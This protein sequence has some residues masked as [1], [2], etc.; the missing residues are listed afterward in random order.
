MGC[1]DIPCLPYSDASRL[2]V[3]GTASS[4]YFEGLLFIL[5]RRPYSIGDCIHVSDPN[6]DTSH[7]ASAFWF[8]EDITLF[9]THVVRL[10]FL[11]ALLMAFLL[12]STSL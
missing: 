11:S 9:S 8:V 7:S 2:V 6:Q 1:F 5:V 4:K 10:D 12:F 3:I